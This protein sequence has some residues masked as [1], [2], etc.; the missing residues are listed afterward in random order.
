[1]ATNP[2]VFLT[3][4]PDGRTQMHTFYKFEQVGDSLPLHAHSFFHDCKVIEGSVIVFD[5]TGM[6]IKVTTGQIVGFKAGRQHGIKA[7]EAGT[8]IVNTI[9]PGQ[10]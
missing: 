3:A 9:E 8:M 5:D 10:G 7:A 2:L 4:L 6:S 1:M